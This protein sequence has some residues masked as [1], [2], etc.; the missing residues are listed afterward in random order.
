M[1]GRLQREIKQSKPF[2]N[3]HAEAFLN[4]LKTAD[5]LEQAISAGMKAYPVSGTQYNVLRILRGAGRD[6]LACSEIGSRMITHDPDITRLL[7]RLETRGLIVRQRD[8]KDRRVV[9][10]RIAKA[11]LELLDEMQEPLDS[12]LE[13]KLRHLGIQKLRTLIELLELAREG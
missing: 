11:G 2:R 5:V 9:V 3:L 1:A 6:G 10:T 4:L 7:D 8:E 12:L 13:T